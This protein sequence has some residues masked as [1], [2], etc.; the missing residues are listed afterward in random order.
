MAP[1]CANLVADRNV[2]AHWERCFCVHA[3]K[4]GKSFTP[5]QI[6]RNESA[7][8]FSRPGLK[9]NKFTL[10]DVTVW[11]APGEHH[12]IKHKA[13][14]RAGEFGLEVYR[15][16]ALLAFAEETG[17]PVLYT[18]HNHAL[19]GGR[20]SMVDRI[21]HWIT[22]DVRDLKGKHRTGRGSSW[23]NGKPHDDVPIYYW[24]ARLW[25]PLSARW[26]KGR[27]A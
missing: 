15:F 21:E 11:T 10:P 3:A 25:G 1:H 2:G 16:D 6:G 8:W 24:N 14:T 26:A 20:D 5:M 22:A 17:Q 23:V 7:A 18:I 13:P 4:A 12:E 19:S 27:A 9:W